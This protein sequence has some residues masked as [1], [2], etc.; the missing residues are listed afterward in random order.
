MFRPRARAFFGA[1]PL[2]SHDAAEPPVE[3][4]GA[5]RLCDVAVRAL[6]IAD[7]RIPGEDLVA[8][9][10]TGGGAG[11]DGAVN[12]ARVGVVESSAGHLGLVRR[13]SLCEVLEPRV[14]DVGELGAPLA[15]DLCGDGLAGLDECMEFFSR[16]AEIPIGVMNVGPSVPE[17]WRA[18]GA[19]AAAVVM[20]GLRWPV[21]GSSLRS[22]SRETDETAAVG[23]EY[24]EGGLGG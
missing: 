20:L 10:V 22:I 2:S 18:P 24:R 14:F 3:P 6:P 13:N 19:G 11:H 23:N 1:V 7:F 4:A 21:P 8:C 15:G 17:G 5:R 12:G 9:D 16:G